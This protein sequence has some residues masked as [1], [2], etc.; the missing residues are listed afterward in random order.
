MTYCEYGDWNRGSHVHGKIG[1]DGVWA[2]RFHVQ[3]TDLHARE[4][5]SGLEASHQHTYLPYLPTYGL[6]KP[7]MVIL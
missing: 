7:T 2:G 5:I 3:V 6:I 1:G 4:D